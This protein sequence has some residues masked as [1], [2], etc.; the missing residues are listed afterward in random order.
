MSARRT[1]AQLGVAQPAG[2]KI[3]SVEGGY[4]PSLDSGL[5]GRR[6]NSP[7]QFGQTPASLEV[8]HSSQNVHSKEQMRAFLAPG[9]R[10][11]LQHSHAGRS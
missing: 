11:R 6:T 8:A 1:A 2:L 7:P 3:R 9:G 5:M 4:L 10:S